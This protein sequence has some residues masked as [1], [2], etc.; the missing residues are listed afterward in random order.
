MKEYHGGI[1]HSE[2]NNMELLL[3]TAAHTLMWPQVIMVVYKAGDDT[4]YACFPQF[5]MKMF[6]AKI[7]NF[8]S[9]FLFKVS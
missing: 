4:K 1:P 5:P 7:E 6:L 8:L 2:S 3:F 9:S